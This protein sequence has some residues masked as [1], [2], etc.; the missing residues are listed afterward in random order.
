MLLLVVHEDKE[1]KVSYELWFK[2]WYELSIEYI[3]PWKTLE[4]K[5]RS[6]LA[7]YGI[8]ILVASQCGRLWYTYICAFLDQVIMLEMIAFATK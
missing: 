5:E 3:D 7:D 6:N 8:V 4:E 1:Y 2:M